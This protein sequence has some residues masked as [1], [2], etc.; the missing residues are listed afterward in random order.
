LY[1]LRGA[2]IAGSSVPS[3]LRKYVRG[4]YSPSGANF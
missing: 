1:S 3:E 4:M 2:V